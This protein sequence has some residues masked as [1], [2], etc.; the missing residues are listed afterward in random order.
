M[1]H[2]A[3]G[4]VLCH[5]KFDQ[6]R[7]FCPNAVQLAKAPRLYA[8][9]FGMVTAAPFGNV[10]EQRGDV[11]HP[12]L[13]PA[14]C[15]LRTQRVFMCVFHHKKAPHIAQHCQDVLVHGVDVEQVV[16]H[17][18]DDAPKHPQIAAQHRGLVH[19][20]HGMGNALGLHQ[21]LAKGIAVDRVTPKGAI[22]QGARVVERAQSA[23]RQ[24]FDAHGL[25]VKQ[26]GFQNR[27]RLAVV[28]I[29]AG[30][31]EHAGFVVKAFVDGAQ[32]VGGGIEPLLDIHQQ[33]L[34]E[35]RDCFGRP[36]VTLHQRLT[37]A[38][39]RPAFAAAIGVAK[40]VGHRSLQV[41]HQS[42]FAPLR[43]LMQA[44]PDQKQQRL[45]ALYMLDFQR[46]GQAL[47]LQF[48]PV[49]AQLRG[50]G[51]PHNRLQITNAAGRLFAVGL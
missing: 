16:L 25:L 38:R 5:Q 24:A 11:Q 23:G 40:A 33:N 10:V 4:Q 29:V 43:G 37:G 15:Q 21:Y 47:G 8:T 27:V 26:K 50:L 14:R 35:L 9:Q 7:I 45:V 44:H 34:V 28:H 13:I 18:P 19:Q 20:P 46:R 2:M 1:R 51:H 42:V 39:Q 17:L 6:C 30:H 41:K 36:V 22:H 31:I 48:L 32:V 12:G 3:H 49:G